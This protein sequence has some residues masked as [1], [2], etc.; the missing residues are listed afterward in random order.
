MEP[1]AVLKAMV[2][3]ESAVLAVVALTRYGNLEFPLGISE[4]LHALFRKINT[5]GNNPK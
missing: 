2:G 5:A 1:S 4:G 3:E